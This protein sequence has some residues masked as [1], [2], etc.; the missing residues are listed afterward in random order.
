MVDKGFTEHH[1]LVA[2]QA[3]A[4][5][6]Q[7]A[8]DAAQADADAAQADA[9]QALSDAAD[10]Q[11]DIDDHLADAV[12]A[13]DASAIS[14]TPGS[15][16]VSTQSQAAIE[17]AATLAASDLAD[18]VSD[19]DPHTQYQKE[20]E[21][22]AANGYAELD[23]GGKVPSAQ[24]PAIAITDVWVVADETAQ[25]AL[26]AEEGDV[27]VRSDLNKSFIHNGGV[28]GT[29]AD[30]QELL[31]PTDAV[32]SVFGRTGA[33]S[34]VSGDYNGSQIT[35]TPAG[36]ISSTDMQ[37]TVNEL[38][39]DIVAEAAARAA[40]DATLQPLDATLTA[41]AGLDATAGVVVETAA[42]TFTKRT[43]TGATD[44]I[45]VQFGSGGSG[46]PKFYLAGGFSSAQLMI[47]GGLYT[48]MVNTLTLS[49][50]VN[51]YTSSAGNTC[52]RI[53]PG[54]ANRNMTGLVANGSTPP[55]GFFFII[56]N[57]STT[58]TLTLK[59]QSASSDAKNRFNL[60][61][62]DHIIPPFCGVILHYNNNGASSTTGRWHVV[63]GKQASEIVFTDITI[64]NTGLHILD[65]NA[66]HDL[67]VK[68]GTDLSADR[69]LTITTDD[70]DQTLTITGSPSL[71][72]TNTG[73]Q[74]LAGL[75]GGALTKAAAATVACG[76]DQTWL[77]LASNNGDVTGVT[78][79]TQLTI[80]G[81]GVGRYRF[82][83]ML[84]YQT[85]NTGTG[86]DVSVN[87]T[88]TL[89]QYLVENRFSSTGQAASTAAATEAGTDAAN[90]IYVS[91]GQRTKDTAIG[92]GCVSVDSANTDMMTMIEGFFVVSVSGDLQIKLAAESAALVCRAMQGSSLL[93][94][95][96]S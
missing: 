42:D 22:G 79:V 20:S 59:N 26:T 15:G 74:T 55:D 48:A 60:N 47:P 64:P 2:A 12:D 53:D 91:Q 96:L 65:T 30:W 38:D 41:L 75:G 7:A 39:G 78:P 35:N 93:L 9:T 23:A 51:D 87:H 85:T 82:S 76:T 18:H 72:G 24:L 40:A 36:T 56:L 44:Q 57:V 81:V 95:K 77:T 16:L 45:D 25:L 37:A 84:I 70:A 86:I 34:A 43:L 32:L 54:A 14:F 17:E 62:V 49:G 73:D 3:D 63:G 21:K 67:I 66:S 92:V 69:T 50:D 68:P 27:A 52:L 61:G 10:A 5:A 71:S 13:H 6:A 58:K 94:Y 83:C 29:M 89:T 31:T 8:A 1:L 33:V 28:A 11:S 90:Q 19:P 46:N 4:D 88:G 80:T